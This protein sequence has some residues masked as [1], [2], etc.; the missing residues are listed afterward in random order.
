MKNLSNYNIAFVGLSV[1]HHKF[2]FELEESFFKDLGDDTIFQ[3]QL[4]VEIDLSKSDTLLTLACNIK[5]I[6]HKACDRCLE[7]VELPIDISKVLHVKITGDDSVSNEDEVVS[8][9]ST[10]HQLNVA[11]HL[12]DFVSLAVPMRVVHDDGECDPE[13][14]KI[15]EEQTSNHEKNID[16]RWKALK[17]ISNK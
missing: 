14:I 8:L 9:G 13:V 12:F 11:Q 4:K 16:P 1:G 7:N 17:K 2:E 15:L 5:G 10:E 6:L 3:P